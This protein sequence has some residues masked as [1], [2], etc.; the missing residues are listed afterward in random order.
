MLEKPAIA[1]ASI[2]ACLRDRY[3]VLA[4]S[5][6]FLPLGAD[7]Y[8][9][10]YRAVG[11]DG[12][13]YF[14]K[15]RLADFDEIAVAVPTFL[16]GLG[17]TSVI[18]PLRSTTGS[19]WAD[20]GTAKLILYPFIEGRN[21]YA[22]GLSPRQWADL[23][24]ALRCMHSATLP[25][26]LR[27]RLPRETLSPHWRDTLRQLLDRFEHDT[28]ADASSSGWPSPSTPSVTT[29]SPSSSVPS[30]WLGPSRPAL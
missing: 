22:A 12:T 28:F 30:G 18:A 2:A 25:S 23:G 16:S 10:V 9:A 13:A 7:R 20:L 5:I 29:S 24:A 26:S 6:T 11:S 21:G 14:V 4:D 17:I 15:L 8:T 3:G 27:E 1:D 19:L